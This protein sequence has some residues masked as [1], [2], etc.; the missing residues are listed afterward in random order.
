MPLLGIT[1]ALWIACLL[2]LAERLGKAVRSPAKDTMLAEAGTDA[3]AI[4]D[5]HRILQPDD[6]RLR[7]LRAALIPPRHHRAPDAPHWCPSYTR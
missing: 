2:V 5:I 4:L 3:P 7:D 1:S 6:V